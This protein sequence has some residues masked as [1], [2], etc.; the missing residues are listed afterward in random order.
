MQ[1][2]IEIKARFGK[3]RAIIVVTEG[4]CCDC[5]GYCFQEADDKWTAIRAQALLPASS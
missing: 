5:E 4:Y 3:S 2:I 1:K